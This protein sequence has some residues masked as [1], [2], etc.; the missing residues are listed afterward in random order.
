MGIGP[1]AHG[2]NGISRSWNVSNNI[3]YLKSI[4]EEKLPNEIEVLSVTD[5]YN[6]YVMTGLRTIWGVS[7]RIEAEFGR[8]YSDYSINKLK[9][10]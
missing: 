8:T 4:Q 7:F 1:S 2:Y 3:I 6:E 10:S 5:R 9:N